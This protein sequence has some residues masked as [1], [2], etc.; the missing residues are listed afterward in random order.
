VIDK[1]K[2]ILKDLLILAAL[3]FLVTT[4]VQRLKRYISVHK[5]SLVHELDVSFFDILHQVQRIAG[6]TRQAI[7]RHAPSD[8]DDISHKKIAAIGRQLDDIERKY[9]RN[10]PALVLL[11][12]IGTTSVVLKEQELQR[13]LLLVSFDLHDLLATLLSKE[14]LTREQRKTMSLDTIMVLNAAYAKEAQRLL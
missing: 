9:S 5:K 8:H 12:P 10:N 6:I 11:G 7:T 2:S 3:V 13:K 14:P 4:L 1:K